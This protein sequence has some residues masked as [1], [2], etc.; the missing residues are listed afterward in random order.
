MFYL[1][2]FQ[3]PISTMLRNPDKADILTA[4]SSQE[5]IHA[6]DYS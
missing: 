1:Y 3:V 4:D 2:H 6:S 5:M